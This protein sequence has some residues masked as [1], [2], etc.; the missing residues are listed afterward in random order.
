MRACVCYGQFMFAWEE[1]LQRTFFYTTICMSVSFGMCTVT[2]PTVIFP[3]SI[4]HCSFFFPR[5][6]WPLNVKHHRNYQNTLPYIYLVFCCSIWNNACRKMR[7]NSI[8]RIT[9]L[10][11]EYSV[12]AKLS[13]GKLPSRSLSYNAPSFDGGCSQ[14][15]LHLACIACNFLRNALRSVNYW[16]AGGNGS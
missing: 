1:Q 11:H 16:N 10:R 8:Q 6:S 15:S 5:S 3:E 4:H 7:P 12:A 14:G 9:V 2:P 13:R